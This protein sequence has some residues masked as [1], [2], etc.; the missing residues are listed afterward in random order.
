MLV[1]G[2]LVA[3]SR[4]GVDMRSAPIVPVAMA[5]MFLLD[6]LNARADVPVRIIRFDDI[7]PAG[8][9]LNSTFEA[10]GLDP[11]ERVYATLCNGNAANGD[12]YVF[13]WD[14][15]TGQRQYLGSLVQSAKK[16]GNIGPNKYWPKK[17]V[18]VKGHTHNIYLDGRM[19]M[20]T[21]NAHGYENLAQHRGI[22][23]FGYDLATGVLTDHSQWQP[24]GVF[25]ERSGMF[26]LDAHPAKNLLV[27]IGPV[28]C[29]IITYNP[30]SGE[31][32]RIPGSP[33][34]DNPQLSGRDMTIVGSKVIYQCGSAKTPISIYD[35]DTNKN[36]TVDFPGDVVLTL[37]YVPT[38][39][40]KK[41]YISDQKTIYEFNTQ[42]ERFRT[43]TTFDPAGTPRQVSPPALSRDETKLYYVIN[44]ADVNG[45]AYIDDLYEFDLVT[46]TRKK[47]MN[48]K[49]V[50][51]GGAKVSGT[52]ATASDGKMYFVFNSDKVGILEI[53]V[54]SR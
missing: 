19:W 14:R 20:G 9:T 40:G 41:V 6:P 18:I 42:T 33:K 45:G 46:G 1:W 12:C 52:K 51:G 23:I 16:V 39:D 26:A 35:L 4:R 44:L 37:G 3:T 10:I 2:N 27:G 30:R 11:E 22:H 53:D 28:N 21:M 29:E 32:K 15:K 47:I 17:E 31:T 8:A 48:L 54:S 49:Q 36:K 7:K 34:E 25:K 38:R 5:C 24:K 43:V 13:R 50:L